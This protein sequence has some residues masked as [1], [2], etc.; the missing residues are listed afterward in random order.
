MWN[1][2]GD[3]KTKRQCIKAG[4]GESAPI[5]KVEYMLTLILSA[6]GRELTHFQLHHVLSA[7]AFFSLESSC[8]SPF[9]E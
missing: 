8:P 6:T 4:G 5:F 9:G 2:I 1:E 3:E 7:C